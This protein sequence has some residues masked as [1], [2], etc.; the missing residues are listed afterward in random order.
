MFSSSWAGAVRTMSRSVS[1][2]PLCTASPSMLIRHHLPTYNS[3]LALDQDTDYCNVLRD[4]LYLKEKYIP[5]YTV[6]CIGFILKLK[7][8]SYSFRAKKNYFLYTLLYGKLRHAKQLKCL[9]LTNLIVTFACHF[10]CE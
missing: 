4:F 9:T 2:W 8:S 10:F 6:Q 1:G 5:G 7:S 3:I